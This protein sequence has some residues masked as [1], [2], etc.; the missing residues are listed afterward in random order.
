MIAAIVWIGETI[1]DFVAAK[2]AKPAKK[3]SLISS[4]KKKETAEEDEGK[5]KSPEKKKGKREKIE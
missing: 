2:P 1:W 3:K 5:D 4:K